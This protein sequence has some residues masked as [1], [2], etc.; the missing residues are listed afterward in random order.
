[1]HH[2]K[3]A[4]GFGKMVADPRQRGM[5][6]TS[7]QARLAFE[8]FAQSFVSKKR[9]FQ[10]NSGIETLIDGLVDGAHAALAEL[11]HNSIPAL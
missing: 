7:Q 1:M 8:L 11:A 6:Q 4:V 2:E 5:M 3:L 9:F 10:C